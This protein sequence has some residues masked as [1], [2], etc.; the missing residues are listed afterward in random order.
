MRKTKRVS[1]ELTRRSFLAATAGAVA[2]GS[3]AGCASGNTV[4]EEGESV[5]LAGTA[6]QVAEEV[7]FSSCMGNC[8]GWG[9][10]INVTVR[11]GKAANLTRPDMKLPDGSPSPYQRICLKGYTN[12]ERMYADTR[13]QYPLKRKGERGAGEWER[14]SWDEAIA[15]ITDTW[16][17]LQG[18]FGPGAVGFLAGSGNVDSTVKTYADRL[19]GLHGRYG[20]S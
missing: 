8:S 19:I 17:N 12:I 6:P 4:G 7:Y 14:I 11:E 10:P 1:P 20:T 16:K 18:D 3:L 5:S 13:L 15:E 9:C 2:A